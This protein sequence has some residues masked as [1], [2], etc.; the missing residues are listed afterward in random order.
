MRQIMTLRDALEMGAGRLAAAGVEAPRREARLLATHLLGAPPG[1]LLDPDAPVEVAAWSDLVG[2][3]ASREPMAFITGKRGFWTLDLAVSTATLIPRP[4]SETLVTAACHLFPA[5]ES[6]GRILDLGT[7][8]GCLLLAALGEF[9]SAFGVG[10][11]RAPQAA[12]LAARNAAANGLAGRSAFLAADWAAPLRASFDLILCNP[13][14]IPSGDVAGL[15]PEVA[16]HEPSSALDGGADGLDAYRLLVASL[17]QLLS[18]GGAAVFE[19]GEGQGESVAALA[20]AAGIHALG[21]DDDLS[22]VGRALKLC[23][24]ADAHAFEK[25]LF[26]STAVGS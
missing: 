5:P 3:R 14:Y 15:M 17:P 9:P 21:V 23:R 6:V 11:D 16:R 22:G 13:P 10:V 2:R 25:K 12:L 4:D 7:G 26:G 24:K 8:T 19:L 20:E 1:R 18:P